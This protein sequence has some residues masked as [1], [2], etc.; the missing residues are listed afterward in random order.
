[1]S[2]LRSE[3]VVVSAPFSFHGSAVRIWPLTE[4]E[5]PWLRWL[6]LIPLAIGLI[7]AAWTFVLVWYICF[8]IL[9]VPYRLIRRSSR[10]KKR[11]DLRHRE[12]MNALEKGK[13]LEK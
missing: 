4:N 6:L 10:K 12:L 9:L 11:D 1:M 3:K 5:N 7:L 2:E 13:T 8:G